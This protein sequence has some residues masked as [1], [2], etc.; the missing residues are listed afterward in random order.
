MIF[1]SKT[2]TEKKPPFLVIGLALFVASFL[3][4]PNI[5]LLEE[6]DGLNRS[7]TLTFQRLAARSPAAD[8]PPVGAE[9]GAF[10]LD[11]ARSGHPAVNY[12]LG[13]GVAEGAHVDGE[14]GA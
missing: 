12:R 10:D 1:W 5:A 8:D 3:F 14:E 11:E 4:L 13:P 7:N 6:D 9:V 2:K